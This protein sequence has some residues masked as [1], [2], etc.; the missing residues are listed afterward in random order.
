MPDLRNLSS[1]DQAGLCIRLKRAS[2]IHFRVMK[3]KSRSLDWLRDDA[4]T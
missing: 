1:R 3:S 2:S 4:A